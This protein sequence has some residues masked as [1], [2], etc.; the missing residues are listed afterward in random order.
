MPL[1]AKER[2]FLD[3]FVYEATNGP[4]FGGPATR[5]LN[6][7][8]IWYPDLSWILTA[9][10]REICA[11]GKVPSGVLKSNPPASPWKSLEEV[12]LR[13]EVLKEEMEPTANVSQL[14]QELA[15]G[16]DKAVHP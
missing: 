1:S 7:S 14:L 8:G 13:N 6:Q 12:K 11:Q 10:Q 16:P 4:P 2:E 5:T 9:Y 15:Q 3:A